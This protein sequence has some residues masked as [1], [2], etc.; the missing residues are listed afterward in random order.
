VGSQAK[1]SSDHAG[2]YRPFFHQVICPTGRACEF[3]SSPPAKNKSLRDLLKSD[4]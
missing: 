4:L 2:A 1:K 3:V